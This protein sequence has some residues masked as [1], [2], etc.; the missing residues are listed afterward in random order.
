MKSKIFYTQLFGILLL[1]LII[2]TAVPIY[3]DKIP[4]VLT[5]EIQ[6]RLHQNKIDW[7]AVRAE[8]RDITLSG[9][10]PTIK[11]HNQAIK[12]VEQ[13]EGVRIVEDKISPKLIIP[14]GMKIDYKK[15]KE[16]IFKGYMPSKESIDNLYKRVESK[17]SQSKLIKQ[18]DIGT[19]EPKNWEELIIVLSLLLQDL[20]LATIN[21]VDTQISL[22][23][24][25]QN[26]KIKEKIVKH[27]QNFENIGY[28][29]QQRII[30]MDESTKVCQE[31]FNT[32]LSKNKIVFETGKSIVKAQNQTLLENLVDISSLCPKAK[33]EIIGHTDNRGNTTKNQE[34]SQNR[35]KAVVA[36]LFQLGIPLEQMSAIGKGEVEPIADNETEEGRAKNRRIEFRVKG[37]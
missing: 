23:G 5:E 26:S 33:L 34:L 37:Y 11:L 19:G 7:V 20:D 24:K 28:T 17:Y 16:L 8:G 21:I 32:L 35:A 30:A 29:I 9:I 18:I 14:Y 22:S 27:L 10:A 1:L 13:V 15:N 3:K 31:K 4:K 12:I 2:V 25:C 36:K 6:N